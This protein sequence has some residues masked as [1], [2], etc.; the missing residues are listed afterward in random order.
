[1]EVSRKRAGSETDLP[2]LMEGAL[3]TQ[4]VA[5]LTANTSNVY[6]VGGYIRDWLLG[7]ESHDVD[8]AVAQDSLSL[9]RRLADHLGGYFVP[10]DRRRGIARVVCYEGEQVIHLDLTRLQGQDLAQDLRRRDFTVNAIAL[11]LGRK[12]PHLIDPHRGREDVKRHLIRAVTPDAFADDPLRL[13]RAVRLA[14]ELDFSI[15]SQTEELLRRDSSLIELSAAE[16]IRYE[17]VKILRTPQAPR[18][19]RFLVDT[20]LLAPIL[21]QLEPHLDP[22]VEAFEGIHQLITALKE[23]NLRGLILLVLGS[24]AEDLLKHLAQPTNGERCR[25]DVLR[26]GALL[27]PLPPDEVRMALLELRFSGYEA[28]CGRDITAHWLKLHQLQSPEIPRRAIYHFFREAG[29]AGVEALLL[30]LAREDE[31]RRRGQL[32]KI[33]TRLLEA[34]FHHYQEIIAPQLLLDGHAVMSELGLETGPKVGELLAALR[35]A[36]AAG[37]VRTRE[38]ALAFLRRLAGN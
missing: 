25:E 14:A 37:E 19:T 33:A 1:M 17:L 16:R 36:Q 26:M 32:A 6:L 35:E 15:E 27:S 23:E 24:F 22:A 9:A 8:F 12:K 13:L 21:P 20:G 18:W 10:L 31:D 11:Q 2:L 7:R 30:A 4:A 28:R 5:W 3:T 29:D 38:E 34:Y